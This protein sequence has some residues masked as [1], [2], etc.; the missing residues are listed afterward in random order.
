MA[1]DFTRLEQEAQSLLA[2]GKTEE[3]Y[4][5]FRQVADHYR[6][7]GKHSQAALCF[8]SA[9]S[10]WGK[11]YGE[12]TFYASAS[13]FEQAA[14]EALKYHDYAYASQL[15]KLAAVNYARDEEFIDFSECFFASK[16]AY[17]RSLF[18]SHENNDEGIPLDK[19]IVQKGAKGTLIKTARW[20]AL[21]VSCLAWGYGERPVR[22]LFAALL[23]IAISAV[24][25]MF[26]GVMKD[27]M[28][29]NPSYLES[30]YFSVVTFTT[31]G[32]GDMAPVGVSRV[33]AMLEAF[34]GIVFMPLFIVGLS[35]KYLRI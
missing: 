34:C 31:L 9:A 17:R 19:E 3:A 7:R 10:C 35:R 11:T 8:A 1:E 13:L 27:G 15:Y 33:I 12:K 6:S 29:I 18:S 32:Y 28:F 26:A 22:T 2:N 4:T 30:L 24:F 14:Q 16:E 23:I 25:Y 5:L 20:L 21:T